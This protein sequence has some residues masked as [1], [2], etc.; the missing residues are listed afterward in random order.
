V[1]APAIV[2][3]ALTRDFGGVRALDSLSLEVPAGAIFAFLGANGAGKTTT[4]HL[5]LGLLEPTS[6]GSRVLGF[7]PS[8]DGAHV[9][10]GCGSLL[11]HA[12]LYERLSAIDNLA[13]HARIN[14]MPRAESERRIRELLA[15]FGLWERRDERA[16]M[17]SRGMKQKL[18]IAR[19]LLTRPPLIFLD[20]PTAGLDPESAVSLRRDIAELAAAERCTVFLTTH[21]LADAEKLATLVG[22]IRDGRLLDAGA[23][24]E[25]RA[26]MSGPRAS[27][28]ATSI[29]EESIVAIDAARVTRTEHGIDVALS[30]DERVAPIVA[31]LVSGGAQIE[32]VRREEPSLEDVFL[33][34]MSR[35]ER[36]AAPS[37]RA[38]TEIARPSSAPR[39]PIF[40]DAATVIWKE[41]RELTSPASS[42]I[43]PK[44]AMSVVAVMLAIVGG[45]AAMLGPWL[46]A[47][48]LPP[49]LG[50]IPTLIILGAV[51][52]SFAGERER[53][54]LETL[55]ASRLPDEALLFGKMA[56]CVLYGT[57]ATIVLLLVVLIGGN[58]GGG[59]LTMYPPSTLLASL[60]AGP[61]VMI[62]LTA[63][64]VLLSVRAATVKEAQTR[65]VSIFFGVFIPIVILQALL[66]DAIKASAK[67]MMMSETGR[68]EAVATQIVALV[69]ID[70]VLLA[71]A[72]ARFRRSRLIELR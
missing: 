12:G 57:G 63:A 66:P 69:V 6:G 65:L 51:C 10:E 16:G 19:V 21:N 36:V 60:V 11:E 62:F 56:A 38:L 71:F 70:A 31:R 59:K 26:R 47:S 46:I 37:R 58:L 68:L 2:C 41:W 17:W 27:I 4:I 15:H 40:R 43:N 50:F 5:L 54:T 42:G 14:R 45:I 22:V 53:H 9:R 28:V 44:V 48:P 64:G 30:T 18:A 24:A 23:P 39:E 55:L 3:D 33:E 34:L 13:F 29:S 35:G 49:L 52:D 67:R 61:L 25:L 32:E 72:S 20:E 7:D 8:R 1:S